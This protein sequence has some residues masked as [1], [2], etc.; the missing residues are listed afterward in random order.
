M[1]P[2]R[3]AAAPRNKT[4]FSS[5][6]RGFCGLKMWILAQAQTEELSPTYYEKNKKHQKLFQEII[7]AL[8]GPMLPWL[9]R[10][11]AHPQHGVE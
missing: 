11:R 7:D 5:P 9:E 8:E 4:P 1:K 2:F 6:Q 10:L 3:V